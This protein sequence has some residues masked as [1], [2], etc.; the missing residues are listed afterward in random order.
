MNRV[1]DLDAAGGVFGMMIHATVRYGALGIAF[2][3]FAGELG[4]DSLGGIRN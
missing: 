2:E 4:S 3:E 1:F